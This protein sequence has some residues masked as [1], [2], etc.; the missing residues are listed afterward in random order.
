MDCDYGGARIQIVCNGR[1]VSKKFF[2][3]WDTPD[4]AHIDRL[5][6]ALHKYL[7]RVM[8]ELKQS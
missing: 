1:T 8:I 3:L 6:L 2:D 5:F 7:D 4:E